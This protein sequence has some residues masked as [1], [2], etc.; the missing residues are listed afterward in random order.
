M[1]LRWQQRLTERH[2]QRQ[3]LDLWRKRPLLTSAPGVRVQ[4]NGQW[5]ISFASNDYLG[6]AEFAFLPQLAQA[7]HQQAGRAGSTASHLLAGHHLPHHLLEDELA[8]W[9][10]VERVLL[11]S[12]GYLANL[13][14]QTALLQDGD[15]LYHDKLNHASLLDGARLSSARFQRYAHNDME[16]LARRLAQPTAGLTMVVTDGVFSMDG[17][18]V[19]L[20]KI[21]PLV[22]EQ[23]GLLVVDEAHSFGV[24][25][26]QGHGLFSHQ[27]QR[28]DASVLRVGT[29]GKAFA[30]SG[31]FIAGSSLL[32]DSIAQWGRSYIY[33]TAQPPYQAS[34]SRAALRLLAGEVGEEARARLDERI[35]V[36]RQGAQA[37]RL[38]L[39][40]SSTPIQPILLGS[41]ERALV[42]QAKLWQLGFWLPAIRPPTVAEGSARLRVSLSAQHSVEQIESLLTA[43]AACQREELL[44]C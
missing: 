20:S 44:S 8:D 25:G 31:A 13:A 35:A 28:A 2:Q 14:V 7:L 27:H 39:L 32:I 42:W 26:K 29:L 1:S 10:G 12:S 33:T 21:L 11:F 41:N 5:L 15:A 24:L 37:L 30:S 9:L 23:E 16:A 6:L 36:F 38:S 22:A 19:C 43:L 34:F 18:A 40:P 4:V 3:A 17:D